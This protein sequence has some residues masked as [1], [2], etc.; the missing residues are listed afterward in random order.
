MPVVRIDAQRQDVDRVD[1]GDLGNPSEER[2]LLAHQADDVWT[3][4]V[5][6]ELDGIPARLQFRQVHEPVYQIRQSNEDG[7]SI[8]LPFRRRLQQHE[9]RVK[10]GIGGRR[11]GDE[12]DKA[13]EILLGILQFERVVFGPSIRGAF[14]PGQ[15][16]RRPFFEIVELEIGAGPVGWAAMDKTPRGLVLQAQQPLDLLHIAQQ[17]DDGVGHGILA[18]MVLDIAGEAAQA[19]LD[20]AARAMVVEHHL[21]HLDIAALELMAAEL[22]EEFMAGVAGHLFEVEIFGDE[23]AVQGR[24][25]DEAQRPFA[26]PPD[27]DQHQGGVGVEIP[28]GRTWG[29][30]VHVG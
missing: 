5:H 2:N 9:G 17:V 13:G 7:V 10:A 11:T 24:G 4:H 23:T 14:V 16:W 27:P 30:I 12:P 28:P 22:L 1:D 8:R 19:A 3:P 26:R 20:H 21:E 18:Q 15:G 25:G 29:R 6:A